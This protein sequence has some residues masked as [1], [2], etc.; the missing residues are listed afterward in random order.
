MAIYI[1]NNLAVKRLDHLET[2]DLEWVWCLVK[3]KQTTFIIC[4]LYMPPNQSSSQYS[5]FLNKLTDSISLAQAYAP[6]N[7]FILG[8]FNAGNTFLETKF[9]NH[10]PLMPFESALHDEILACD[11]QQIIT[12][13]TRY[14]DQTNTRIASTRPQRLERL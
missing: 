6:H 2:P 5:T 14:S 1:R 11:L 4:S 12:E 7:I 8:D 10:S 3:S 9:T 13:P